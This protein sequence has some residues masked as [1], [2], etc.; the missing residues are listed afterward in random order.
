[1]VA[2]ITLWASSYVN[3]KP[4]N[5]MNTIMKKVFEAPYLKVVDVKNDVIATSDPTFHNGMGNGTQLAPGRRGMF[6][7]DYSEDYDY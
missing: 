6:D 1:M 4:S 7:D 2:Y 5:K 3:V